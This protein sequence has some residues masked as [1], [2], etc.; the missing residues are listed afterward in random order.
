MKQKMKSYFIP[1]HYGTQVLLMSTQN[2]IPENVLHMA[3]SA[4]APL[5]SKL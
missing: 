5:L 3:G 4:D 1:M 2:F